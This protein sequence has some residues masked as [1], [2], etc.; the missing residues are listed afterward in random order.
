MNLPSDTALLLRVHSEHRW[1]QDELAGVLDELEDPTSLSA[2]QMRAA[3]AYLDVTWSEG[4]T[5]ARQTDCAYARLELAATAARERGSLIPQAFSYYHWLRSLRESLAE[6]V[7]P[8]LGDTSGA[9][10]RG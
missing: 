8:F 4:V 1:L 2:E 5:R 7:E 10:S 6:R 3:L 9:L